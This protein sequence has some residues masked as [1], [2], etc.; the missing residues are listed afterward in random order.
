MSK[1]SY[2]DITIFSLSTFIWH[3]FVYEAPTV[4]LCHSFC[5]IKCNDW[6][7]LIIK[8][9]V[10][11]KALNIN[12][13]L[14]YSITGASWKDVDEQS[15]RRQ[16]KMQKISPLDVKCRYENCF[17][18]L[19]K[20]SA[21][22]DNTLATQKPYYHSWSGHI[23]IQGVLTTSSAN[24]KRKLNS[25]ALHTTNLIRPYIKLIKFINTLMRAR[26]RSD[27]L[28]PINI[29]IYF[30]FF[31]LKKSVLCPFNSWM[32]LT[33]N[34]KAKYEKYKRDGWRRKRRRRRSLN[35]I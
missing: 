5:R 18:L 29:L 11:I 7:Y 13:T 16:N 12:A 9:W 27:H 17:K 14:R 30:F 8:V 25:C 15:S 35:H 34:W 3:W 21:L 2:I 10:S 6:L 31:H 32:A 24:K 22:V 4:T 20:R 1:I 28:M 23:W 19:Y 26:S 33:M